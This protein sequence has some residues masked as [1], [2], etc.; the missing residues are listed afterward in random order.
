MSRT[1][2]RP[3]V[4]L[5]GAAAALLA[6][7][8][9]AAEDTSATEADASES[10]AISAERCAENEAAGAITFLTGYQYQASASILDVVAASELGYFDDLCLDVE[11]QPGTGDTGQN[12]QLVA[13]DQVQFTSV[14]QQ[15]LLQAYDTGIELVGISSYSNV[16]LEI[17]MTMPEI[18]DLADLDGTILGHKGGLPPA[19][20]AMLEEAGAD[21]DSMQQV[22]VGYDPSILPRGQVD[23]LTGF[24]SNEPN[25]LAAAGEDVTVWRPY[26]Y[27]VPSSLGA[28]AANPEFAAEHPTV[29]EDFLRATFHAFEYC[30]TAAE[31]CVAFTADLSGE[32]Y[33]VDHNVNIWNTEAEIV[34]E[35]QPEGTNL[36]AIDTDNVLAIVA[37]LNDFSLLE[38]DIS[39]DTALGLFDPSF[40]DAIF[41]DG[42]LVWPAP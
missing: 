4:A 2:T 38:N 22:V 20:A 26:D 19:V 8:A 14:S 15:N 31:E 32:G 37:M 10:T 23:S 28:F 12:T 17:L 9:C 21:V 25:L 3:V 34:R 29:V 39:D 11:I 13:S 36:G 1:V 35:A 18:E 30:E 5:A 33:D 6:F 24:I 40:V 16:G 27:G 41:A 42:E 7:T